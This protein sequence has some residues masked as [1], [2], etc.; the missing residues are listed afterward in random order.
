MDKELIFNKI[1]R[2]GKSEKIFKILELCKNKVVLDVGCV[3]Q[4]FSYNNP[5]WPHRLIKNICLEIDGVDI[6]TE[7][8]E[9]LKKEGYTVF[10][11]E[12]LKTSG[13]KYDVVL[14]SD[15]IEHIN[16]PVSF[17]SFYSNYLSENG[18][19]IITTPNPHGVRNFTNILFRNNYSI[20]PEHTFWL[21]PKTLT[22][23]VSRTHL[24][25]KDFFW[26]KEYFTLK[27]IKGIKFKIIFLINTFFIKIRSGFS[28]NFMYIVSK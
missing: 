8:I 12:E 24:S 17:L 14:M 19:I 9:T 10:S 18:I 7:G 2:A 21:C 23:I 1:I 15:V 13:K 11:T 5:K 4:D 20:N 28:P 27:E 26:L 3:G 22:E 25:F 6:E 16:D